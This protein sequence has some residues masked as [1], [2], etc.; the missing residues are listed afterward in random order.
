[1]VKYFF[2]MKLLIDKIN[3]GIRDIRFYHYSFLFHSRIDCGFY[4]FK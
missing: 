3:Y 4:A 1:M 2:I